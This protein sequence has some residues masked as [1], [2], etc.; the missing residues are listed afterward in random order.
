MGKAKS[1]ES[2]LEL[3]QATRETIERLVK[4]EHRLYQQHTLA[5]SDHRRLRAIHVELDG[6][7]DMLRQRRALRDA[8]P[9][10]DPAAVRPRGKDPLRLV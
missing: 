6:Y 1:V 5:D 2:N 9:W 8:R 10:T 3:D 4:E 7:F